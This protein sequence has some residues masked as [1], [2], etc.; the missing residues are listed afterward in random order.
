MA[1]AH[2][3]LWRET[4]AH[5]ARRSGALIAAALLALLALGIALALASY[6]PGDPSLSTAAG[7][8]AANWLGAPGAIGA[9][10]LLALFGWPSALLVPLIL[11]FAQ[12]L[13]RD[14]PVGAWRR[15]TLKAVAGIVL[16]GAA[17]T[18]LSTGAVSGLPAGYGGALGM[19]LFAGVRLAIAQI[20]D[21][22]AMLWSLRAAAMLIGLGGLT[23][24]AM[25]YEIDAGARNWQLR[26][27]QRRPR[28]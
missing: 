12:R 26:L 1:S 10:A 22:V 16:I 17:F 27:P 8:P 2:P 11:L 13:W 21:P 3:P 5:G 7:G 19:A 28:D 15:M 20:G 24:Y 25:S 6:R 9:D 14:V 23:L 4:V 18:S